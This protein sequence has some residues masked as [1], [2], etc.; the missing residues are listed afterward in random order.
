MS[1]SSSTIWLASSRVGAS[2]SAAGWAPSALE[3]LGERD[4]ESERLAR[5]GGRLDEHVAARKDVGEDELLDGERLVDPAT[6][7]R[8]DDRVR[9]AEI[10]E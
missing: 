3:A 8:G 9:D 7:E 4:P 10:G 2:T 1:C 5:A 6:G